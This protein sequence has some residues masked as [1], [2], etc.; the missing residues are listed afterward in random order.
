[1][2]EL[3]SNTLNTLKDQKYQ[4]YF[5]PE[6]IDANYAKFWTTYAEDY[7]KELSKN[8][9]DQESTTLKAWVKAKQM[10]D[11]NFAFDPK[12][13]K[14]DSRETYGRCALYSACTG[15]NELGVGEKAI[16]LGKDEACIPNDRRKVQEECNRKDSNSTLFEVHIINQKYYFTL[17]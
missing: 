9:F 14:N 4:P 6:T 13:S 5:I 15:K 8:H 16:T 3:Y 12:M 11:K 1:M 7:L 2:L 17:P 10:Y